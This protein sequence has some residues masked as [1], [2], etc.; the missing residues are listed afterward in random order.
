MLIPTKSASYRLYHGGE[1]GN[2]LRTW[3]SLVSVVSS[4]FS[5]K[6]VMRYK[7]ANGGAIY[8][9]LGEHLN[10]N[11]AAAAVR[12]WIAAGAREDQIAYNEA[13]PDAALILQGEVMLSVEHVSLFWSAER[14][15]MR[16]AMNRG[17]QWEGLRALALLKERLF[18]SSWEDVNLLLERFP[19]AVIEFS[20]Y[21][22]A[23]GNIP[24]RNA[25]IW[26]VRDY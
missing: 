21:R 22:H 16:R 6:I 1:F 7:G 17:R 2:K 24:G 26:E 18:P 10:L 19:T 14:T 13:A 20:A 3:D 9:R 25:V 23:V 8:P 11:E 4:G 15:T 12:S 5:G